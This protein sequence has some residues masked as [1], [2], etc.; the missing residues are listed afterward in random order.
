MG[1]AVGKPAAACSLVV[2]LVLHLEQLLAQPACWLPE[3]SAEQ[4][5]QPLVEVHCSQVS[6]EP[7]VAGARMVEAADASVVDYLDA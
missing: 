7:V 1:L 6:V 5:S 3:Q 2:V 4:L